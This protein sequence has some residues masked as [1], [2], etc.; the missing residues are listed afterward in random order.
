ML[1]FFLQFNEFQYFHKYSI[2]IGLYQPVKKS[3]FWKKFSTTERLHTVRMVIETATEHNI[4]IWIASVV[5]RKTFDTV[6]FWAI[7]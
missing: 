1:D 7:N 5:F 2:C 4:L 3:G 6:E